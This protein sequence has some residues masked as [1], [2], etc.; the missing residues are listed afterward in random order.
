MRLMVLAA[1]LALLAGCD[2]AGTALAGPAE[3]P[4]PAPRGP[5][6]LAPI[7]SVPGNT[8]GGPGSVV[9]YS[10]DGSEVRRWS[11]HIVVAWMHE[12]KVSFRVDGAPVLATGRWYLEGA[13]AA[14]R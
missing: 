7:G 6:V 11:G 9:L 12:D 14:G 8:A 10:M 1:L 3:D 5:A 2:L 13:D 4:A